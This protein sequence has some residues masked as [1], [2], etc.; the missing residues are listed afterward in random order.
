M[1]KKSIVVIILSVLLTGCN[2]TK[3]NETT[4][5]TISKESMK[6]RDYIPK[7]IVIAHRGT[8]YWAPEETEPAFLWARN[9]GS[10]YLEFD[11]QMTKD[12]VLV[13]FH[14][15]TLSRTTNVSEVF[16]DVEK[17]T[18]NDFTLKELRSLDAGSWFNNSFPSRAKE[19]YVG[20]TIMTLEDVAMIAE[21]YR[22]KK[23]EKGKPIKDKKLGI[24]HGHYKYE[25]DPNDNRNRPGLYVETK[26]LH[27]EI[28]LAKELKKLQWLI[29]DNPKKIKTFEGKVAIANTN[30]RFVLQSF[31]RRSIEQLNIHLPGVP[32]CLLLWEP[33]MKDNIKE[34]YIE[35]INYCIENDVQSIG[36]SVPGGTNNYGELNAPWMSELVH[37]AGLVIHP[38]TFDTVAQLTEYRDRVEGVFT[39]RADLA[40]EFYNRKSD[41]SAEEILTELG[42]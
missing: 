22:I 6:I 12:S 37:K 27:L 36:S 35:T 11:I 8:T 29:T 14:D 33:K 17:P 2:S 25:K 24:W 19:T 15:N 1:M 9:I 31:Y 3:K 16:P 7:D 4:L 18:T 20:I 5:K 26:K 21:G 30:A 32:K 10:D 13:A 34:N 28:L 38:Y 39:N 42:Y 41:K 40:L 23:D